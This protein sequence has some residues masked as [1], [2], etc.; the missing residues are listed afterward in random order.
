MMASAHP[1]KINEPKNSIISQNNAYLTVF[2]HMGLGYLREGQGII[3][4]PP[5]SYFF[6]FWLN[7]WLFIHKGTQHNKHMGRS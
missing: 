1:P 6:R 5:L 7:I 2:L 4:F 3:A